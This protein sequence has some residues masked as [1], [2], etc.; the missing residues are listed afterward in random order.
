[1]DELPLFRRLQTRLTLLILVVVAVLAG[2]TV[3]Q[4]TRSIT[5]ARSGVEFRTLEPGVPGSSGPG[6]TERE[7]SVSGSNG[8]ASSGL[9]PGTAVPAT[10]RSA[11]G[12]TPAEGGPLA[13]APPAL[14]ASEAPP[15][16]TA[17]VRSSLINLIA[18][19]LLTLVG[20]TVF[21]RTLLTEP[22]AAL[23]RGTRALASGELGVT[24][25][26]TSTSELG[27]LAEAFNQMSL[28]LAARTDELLASNEALKVSEARYQ[29][30]IEGSNDG[31]WD[32][33]LHSGSMYMSPRWAAMLG[34]DNAP[35]PTLEGWLSLVHPDDAAAV[36]SAFEAGKQGATRSIQVDHR[37]RHKDGTWRWMQARGAALRSAEGAVIRMAGSITDIT[38]RVDALTILENRVQERTE[39]LRALLELSNSTALTLELLPLLD[40]ILERLQDTVPFAG[41]AV[42]EP[43]DDDA[44]RPLATRGAHVRAEPDTMARVLAERNASLSAD[45]TLVAPLVVRDVP[46]GVMVLS[47]P[48]GHVSDER[49]ALVMAF[50]NQLAVALE[51][52]RLYQQ[53]TEQAAFEERQH[54]ARELHDSVSQA[55]YAI[56]L[57]THTAVR[58]VGDAPQGVLDALSYVENLAQAALAEMRAL[59]FV[60]RPESLEKEGLV[61]VLNKQLDAMETRHGVD[62][63]LTTG[64]EPELP[65]AS[66]QV[67]YRVAQEALHN[68]VKHAHAEHVWVRLEQLDDQVALTIRDDG[69]GFVTDQEFPGHLGLK[70]M[71]ERMAAAGGSVDIESAPGQG[72]TVSVRLPAAAGTERHDSEHVG[73]HAQI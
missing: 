6:P 43:A 3:V 67:L 41:A 19:F 1:M 31:I 52:A 10:P 60:L 12:A 26:V 23:V 32:W 27:M 47:L 20:A 57:G 38:E 48:A 40:Q 72:T 44:F 73:R 36:R 68:V 59:I 39:D 34:Y 4:V 29:L 66:K 2:A 15:T 64:S 24:L 65:F 14:P 55:L 9:E 45:G 51:N 46:R 58:Q 17:L 13:T 70:S 28:G 33:D 25:P 61:G 54:L 7:P 49:R 62:A 30:A 42:F 50:A 5:L 16:A 18:I 22:I 37:L 63:E 71:R 35:A 53:A 11:P 21:S 8:P 69:E 56:L